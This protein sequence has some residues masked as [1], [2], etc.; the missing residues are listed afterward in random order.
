MVVR[1]FI[2]RRIGLSSDVKPPVRFT[3][4]FHETDT[5]FTYNANL[6]D[7]GYQLH[8]G[9]ARTEELRNKEID[10]ELN[11]VSPTELLEDSPFA[12]QGQVKGG[13]I[14]AV[15]VDGSFYGSLEGVETFNPRRVQDNFVEFYGEVSQKK[16]FA[17]QFPMVTRQHGY[18]L[19]AEIKGTIKRALMGFSGSQIYSTYSNVFWNNDIGVAMGFTP[20]VTKFSVFSND[21]G[22]V[23]ATPVSFMKDKD[24]ELHT[25]EIVLNPDNVVCILDDDE[26]ITL[27][28]QIPPL[29]TPLYVS[30]YGIE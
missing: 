22:G 28:T 10:L 25:F 6:T 17:S 15:T 8:S 13:V 5:G 26:T 27:T 14:P 29:T 9:S 21:G 30:C 2:N 16:G 24:K 20:N 7:S 12:K 18:S 11:T 4:I 3:P 19:K 1:N 23:A